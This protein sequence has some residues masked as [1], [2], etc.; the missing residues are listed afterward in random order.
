MKLLNVECE[1]KPIYDEDDKYIEAKL[2]SYKDKV[3][4]T[5]RKFII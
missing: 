3:K 5:K 1:S 4:D 2:K